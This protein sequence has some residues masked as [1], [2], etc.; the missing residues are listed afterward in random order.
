MVIVVWLSIELTLR[1]WSAGCRSRYQTWKG[2]LKFMRNVFCILGKNR[3]FLF[4]INFKHNNMVKNRLDCNYCEYFIDNYCKQP[5]PA[6]EFCSRGVSRFAV[7]SNF[8]HVESGS[9]SRHLAS[10]RHCRLG[11]S[12]SYH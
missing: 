9:S 8:A 6:Q 12:T 3:F 5:K 10:L 7:F 11:P 2:R 4:L 1:V